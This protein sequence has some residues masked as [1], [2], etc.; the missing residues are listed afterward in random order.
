MFT[1]KLPQSNKV[2]QKSLSLSEIHTSTFR[3]ISLNPWPI[4]NYH[5]TGNCKTF[6][7]RG[8]HFIYLNINSLLPKIDELR[9]IVEI[10][11]P[12][13]IDI[14]E[15]KL[16]NSISDPEISIYGCCV[17]GRDQNRKGGDVICYVNNTICYNTKNCISNILGKYLYRT[18]HSKSKTSYS[19]DCL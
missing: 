2:W 17:I 18:S 9:E 5:L 4:Q 19:W 1:A 10:S 8:L 3:G 7:N 6:R 13:G 14:R 15:T 16:D 11:N 12:T